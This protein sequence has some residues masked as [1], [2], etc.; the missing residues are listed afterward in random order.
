M[1]LWGQ[2]F[3]V[4]GRRLLSVNPVHGCTLP[5][6]KN[7]RRPI[8]TEERYQKLLK[9][10]AAAEPTGRFRCVLVLARETGRRINAICQVGLRDV[11]TTPEQMTAALAEVGQPIEWATHWPHGA[12]VWR[13]ASDKL[14]YE[15]L[16]PLSRAAREALDAYMTRYPR[17]GAVPLFQGRGKHHVWLNEPIKKEIAGY[18]LS[19]AERLAKVPRLARGGYHPWRR[20]WASERRHLPAQDVAAAGGWRSLK[21]MQSAYQHADAAGVFSVTENARTAP[22]SEAPGLT[23]DTPK[24]EVTAS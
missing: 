1:I 8:A 21:V 3:R 10:A 14:G 20:L 16:S 23:S 6:E 12:I 9:V 4:G 15:G 5:R 7:A 22:E 24:T 18:W 17:V 19:R 13:S 2:S 11:L